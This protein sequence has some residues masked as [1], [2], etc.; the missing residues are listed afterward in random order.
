MAYPFDIPVK[1]MVDLAQT[2]GFNDHK[3]ERYMIWSF[4]DW[5]MP[6]SHKFT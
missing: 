6:L 4:M 3:E 2:F 5:H 1:D